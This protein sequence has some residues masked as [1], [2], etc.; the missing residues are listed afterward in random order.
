MNEEQIREIYEW[1]DKNHDKTLSDLISIIE[2][3]GRTTLQIENGQ[4]REALKQALRNDSKDGCCWDVLGEC[5]CWRCK[6]RAIIAKDI[7]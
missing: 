4:L 5:R 2:H 7:K 6:A 3:Y 1:V